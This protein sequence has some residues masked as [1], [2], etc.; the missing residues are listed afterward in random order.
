VGSTTVECSGTIDVTCEFSGSSSLCVEYVLGTLGTPCEVFWHG[1]MSGVK[2]PGG[3]CV[4][5]GAAMVTVVSVSQ[6]APGQFY[7]GPAS[8]AG[9]GGSFLA[10]EDDGVAPRYGPVRADFEANCGTDTTGLTEGTYEAFT[11]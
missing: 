7:S 4:V 8:L 5:T 2:A 11:V 10:T 3:A 9:A 6:P 1:T